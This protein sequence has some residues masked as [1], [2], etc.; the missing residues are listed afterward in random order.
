MRTLKSHAI[1][2]LWMARVNI[3]PWKAEV[4]DFFVPPALPWRA[5]STG[6]ALTKSF[7]TR[8]LNKSQAPAR[9]RP[10][11]PVPGRF[12]WPEGGGVCKARPFPPFRSPG[13]KFLAEDAGIIGGLR[14]YAGQ[15]RSCSPGNGE[16]HFALR[17]RCG[18]LPAQPS[19][20]NLSRI[21]KC[22]RVRERT[23]RR[24]SFPVAPLS[25]TGSICGES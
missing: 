5:F 20:Q 4:N 6:W 7:R 23:H 1:D 16:G 3:C 18:G 22:W 21:R 24:T 9:L 11:F 13:E 19:S 8:G 14:P 10:S 2:P 17:T 25:L 12:P 15:P